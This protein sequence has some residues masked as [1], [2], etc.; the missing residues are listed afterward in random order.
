MIMAKHLL[1]WLFLLSMPL[2]AMAQVSISGHVKDAR[3]NEP[4][5]GVSVVQ[6]S[7]PSVGTI[8]DLDGNFVLEVSVPT[9]LSFSYIGYKTQDVA[10]KDTR[11]LTV[12]LVEN[13]EVLD[14]VVVVGYGTQ[15]KV[16]LTGSVSQVKMDDI[17][18]DR[19]VTSIAEAL[20]GNVPGL[21]LSNNSGEPGSGYDFQIRGTSSINGGS[22]LILVDGVSIDISSLN[23]NDIESVSVLKDASAAAVYGAR[24]AFGVILITTKKANKETKPTI[25]FSAKLTMSN[26]QEMATRATPMQ[27]VQALLDKGENVYTGGQLY[28][29]WL[30]QLQLYNADPSQ[31][32]DGYVVIDDVKYW[33]RPT[34]QTRDLMTTGFQQSY[35][36]S[37]NGGS[38]KT[39]YRLSAGYL[40]EDGVLVTNKDRYSRYNITSFVGTDVTKWLTAQMTLLYT[41]TDKKDPTQFTTQRDVWGQAVAASSFDPTGGT[42][43]DGKYYRYL[44][45]AHMMESVVPDDIK[46]DRL[47]ILGRIILKPFKDLTVTGEYSINKTFYSNRQY[48]KNMTDFADGRDDS[49]VPAGAYSTYRMQKSSTDYNAANV[50]AT[51]NHKWNEKHDF[52]AM[53]GLNV[54]KYSNQNLA[55][56]RNEM[57]N[58]EM[59]SLSQAVGVLTASDSFTDNAILGTFYRF[60]YAFKDKYLLEATGRYDGSSKFPKGHRFGFFPSFSAGWRINQENFLKDVKWLSNLKIRGSWGSIGNQNISE[61]GYL[62]TMSSANAQWGINGQKPITLNTP[63]L[64]RSNF[65]W[66][67]VQT[68]NFGLDWG[69]FNNRLS[70][71]FDIFRRKTMNMLGPGADYPSA[72]GAD[73][74]LQNAANMF[75]R[76]WELAMN[77][78][79]RIGEVSYSI[80]FN[81]SDARSFI[82]KYRNETKSLDLPYYEGMELGEIWG[83][84]SDRLYTVDDFVEGT[85][86]TTGEGALSGG[87]LKDGIPHFQGVNPN[88]GDMLFKYA[89]ENGLIWESSNTVDDPG[90][91]RIIGN[92]TPR[93][94]YGI[95]GNVSWKGLSLSFLL[96]GIGKRD[97][98]MKNSLTTPFPSTVDRGLY[99]NL[100]DYWTPDNQDAFFTRL[101]ATGNANADANTA[102]QTRYL[103]DASY[104]DIKSVVLSYALPQKWLKKAGIGQLS[105]FINGEN[106]YSFNHMPKGLHPD[107]KTRGVTSGVSSGGVTYPVMRKFTFGVNLSF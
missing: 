85:L 80:G 38:E 54:E 62:P 88:P 69:L 96:Q 93:Y 72:L 7:N 68:G 36:V 31:F 94:Y 32:P 51:Y 24:A 1:L 35:D 23:P 12:T 49:V 55:A 29:T 17:A 2:S 45:P 10:V 56:N 106:L 64:V 50:Y 4:L 59:P 82:T 67:E 81:L 92:N 99:T 9:E 71:S 22:P 3:T 87:T 30:E 100:L 8:T 79:D 75:T 95:S 25:N 66:E 104:L 107:S 18:K 98:W 84:V 46:Y 40:G 48:K 61:Y 11:E 47:N 41:H 27:T 13:T 5:I 6:K 43:I 63:V 78:N 14:E 65:T 28:S 26:P 97:L 33:L 102:V 44:T 73:A 53:V 91:R 86:Q 83:Y 77:W 42:T 60:N 89:D 74:P 39:T 37:V 20:M 103:F 105:V 19:P 52:T 76:G 90:S 15:K 16:N 101:Y 58:D 21:S 70:G 57:I 34:D